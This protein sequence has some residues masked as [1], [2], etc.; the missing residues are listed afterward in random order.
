MTTI[1]GSLLALRKLHG[2]FSCIIPEVCSRV[3]WTSLWSPLFISTDCIGTASY[4]EK[5]SNPDLLGQSLKFLCQYKVGKLSSSIKTIYSLNCSNYFMSLSQFSCTS[6]KVLSHRSIPSDLRAAG[7]PGCISQRH[8]A[9]KR[10]ESFN[11]RVGR[12]WTHYQGMRE[13]INYDI[14]HAMPAAGHEE[15]ICVCLQFAFT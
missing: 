2:Y 5:D 14:Y 13:N 10:S 6:D 4:A 9:A 11:I 1:L 7:E 3:R 12:G 8:T 15:T